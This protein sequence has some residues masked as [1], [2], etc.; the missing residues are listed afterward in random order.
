MSL[1]NGGDLDFGSSNLP[2]RG[3]KGDL[4]EGGTKSVGLVY[5]PKY[6]RQSGCIHHGWESFT[7]SSFI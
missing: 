5:S 1:Q 7:N 3:D 6:L 2:L 4:W